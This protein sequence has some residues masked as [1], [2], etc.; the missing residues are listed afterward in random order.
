MEPS[1]SDV[2]LTGTD[3]GFVHV[4]GARLHNLREV[5]VDL[6]RGRLVAFTGV[7]GSGKSSL[8]FGT[9]HGESQ[10]RY[11]ESVAPFARRLIGSAVDPRVDSVTGMPPTV[12]LEQRTTG[13]GSRSTVGTTTN[14]SNAI[15][16]LYSRAGDHPAD[17]L[18]H[19]SALHSGRLTSDFFSP[20]TPDGACPRCHG[21]G[22]LREPTE[23]SMVPDPSLS[24]ASGAIAAWPGAWLGKNFRD[25]LATLGIDIHRPWRELP[26]ET[27]DWILHTEEQPVVTVHPEREP[28]QTH[29]TYRGQWRSVE[30][31]LRD[32]VS[33]SKAEV[34]RRRALAHFATATCPLCEGHRLGPDA[35]RVTYVGLPIW[36]LTQ[37]P[38]DDLLT[39]LSGRLA[40]LPEGEGSPEE[41]AE[42]ILLPTVLPVLRTIVGLGL[43]H[44]A[45]DRPSRT[46]ST[47]EL[48]RLRLAAQLRSGLFGVAYVLDEPSAGLHPSETGVLRHL[49]DSFLAEGNS[50]LLVEHDMSMVADADWV[51]DVGP[52]A[53]TEGGEVLYSG[54]VEGLGEADESVTARYLSPGP[55]VLQGADEARAAHGW[56]EIDGLR[57]RTLRDVDLRLPLGAFTAV[58]GVSGAGK[59]TLV[60]HCLG[61]ILGQRVRTTV[62]DEPDP[63]ADGDPAANALDAGTGPGPDDEAEQVRHGEV[64]GAEGIDR[65][66]HITQKPIGRTPRSCLATYTG[67][68]DRVRRLFADTPQARR[69]GWGVGRF[70][71]NV[72]AGRCPECSGTGHIEVE[73]VFLP[74]SYAICPRCHGRRYNDET[75]EVRWDGF[76]IAEVLELSVAQARAVFAE[77]PRISRALDALAAIGLG[78]LTL[79]QPATELSGGE[80]QRIKLAAELQRTVRG[81]SVY[82]LDEPT[83]GLHP[84]DVDLLVTEL[85]RLV[86]AGQTVVVVEHD[87]RV[88]AHSDHVIDLGPGAGDK[89]GRIIAQGAPA[90]IAATA[91]SVTGAE[92]DRS[93]HGS[94]SRAGRARLSR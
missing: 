34:S 92:L 30:R 35:L 10:R 55:L 36:R 15:R 60:T 53:G 43:G 44:L 7:S 79:G 38:L 70:S 17:V 49:L 12:A 72:A 3:D 66:V 2:A 56:L 27:R 78:Y 87:Q 86:D 31:Y 51:L 20:N 85:N 39:S 94:G 48:Q 13:G 73:L 4:R 37:L 45:L 77:D 58:T 82:L 57:A 59:S 22:V 91:E 6:P 24:I 71:Y 61:T 5:D 16:L 64:R 84:A 1:A 41:E 80:A 50:V 88:I 19:G 11:L 26:K 46:L 63:S 18:E 76:T 42:R 81:H 32:T 23:S 9:I 65:L 29:G 28:G 83:S 68:F 54:V 33:S 75:L 89:G 21:V 69:R 8:A 93:A 25:I 74:G 62:A 67:F 47:G 52:G 14:L 40:A 90:T